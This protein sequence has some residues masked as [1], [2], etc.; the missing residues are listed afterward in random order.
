MPTDISD[1]LTKYLTDAHSIEEQALA[2][3]K[4]APDIAGEPDLAEAFR[5]HE[6][7][8]IGHEQ[9]VKHLLEARGESTST[10]K[11]TVMKVGGK[12]FVLFARAQPDTPGKL[13]AHALSYEALEVASYELLGRVAKQAGEQH[14][15]DAA[16]GILAD[17]RKMMGRL[18]A[19]YDRAVDASLQAVGRDD[20]EE[21]LRKYLADAHAIE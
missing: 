11:D 21:Q 8:T 15:Q 1:Q 7:E 6:A 19:N 10:V 5:T 9:L 4:T 14:V 20:L 12:G 16:K 2:Q 18:E 13:L 17:E 3:L